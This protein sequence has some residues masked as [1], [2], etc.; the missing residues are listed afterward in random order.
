MIR[1]LLRLMAVAAS[2]MPSLAAAGGRSRAPGPLTPPDPAVLEAAFKALSTYDWG[3]D[4]K[5]VEPI[6]QAINASKGDA[7][8]RKGIEARLIAVLGSAAPRDA[9]DFAC[10]RLAEMGTVACVPALAALLPDQD[11]SHMARY[12]LERMT[13]PEAGQALRDALPKTS[14]RARVGIIN[15]LGMRGDTD[16]VAALIPLLK[17]ADAEVASAAAAA[18]GRAGTPEAAKA[19]CD[20]RPNA[21]KALQM[22][23]VDACL[24]AAQRLLRKGDKEGAAKIYESLE[25]KEQPSQVRMAAF[26]GLVLARPTESTPMLL[27][28]LDGE[29]EALRLQAADLVAQV[30]GEEA[31]KTFAAALPNLPP[32]GQVALLGALATRGDAAAKPAVAEAVKSSDKRVRQAAAA[33]LGATG[34]ASDAALLA[35]IAASDDKDAASAA[36]ASLARLKGDGVNEGIVGAMKDAVPGV[37]A[38]LIRALAARGAKGCVATVVESVQDADPPVRVAALDALAELGGAEQVATAVKALKAAKDNAERSAADKALSALC[39]KTREGAADAVVAGLDG[40]DAPT[41]CLLL[42]ALSRAGGA[43]ALAAVRAA[44]TDKDGQVADEAVRSLAEWPDLSAAG[45]LLDLAKGAP[46]PNHQIVALRGYVRLAEVEKDNDAKMK[47]LTEAAALAKRPEEK[48]QILGALGN[49]PTPDSLKQIVAYLDEPAL[50]EEASVAAVKIGRDVAGK[51]RDLVREAM[52]K[53]T[54]ESKNKKNRE[55]AAKILRDV[56]K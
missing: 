25:A 49:V 26:Q 29:N 43:K 10:R 51:N 4:G 45:L 56:K 14:G 39:M 41:R 23:A 46:K 44:T 12:A 32:S 21:P 55:D 38:A 33:A 22:A 2:L 1:S 17:E 6:T 37:R 28:A 27:K 24:D 34:N 18:L 30:P 9:K 50:I 31:T 42:R 47:I 11:L 52:E 36:Q 5:T 40:A 53:I 15:S 16:A 35:G 7:A 3:Q 48:K 8:T 13:Y 19:V 20:F 54:Q